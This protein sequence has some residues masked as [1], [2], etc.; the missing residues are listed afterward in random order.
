MK[1]HNG[2][3]RAAILQYLSSL[4]ASYR[5]V[6][7]PILPLDLIA[8][9]CAVKQDSP[10]KTLRSFFNPCTGFWNFRISPANG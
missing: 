10:S 2:D 9:S 8:P 5:S 3:I 6:L 4:A 7:S 1:E